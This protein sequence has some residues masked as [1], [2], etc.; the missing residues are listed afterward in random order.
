M[1]VTGV[2]MKEETF[3]IS[4]EFLLS[5][6]KQRYIRIIKKEGAYVCDLLEE[7][8]DPL[9]KQKR[10]RTSMDQRAILVS[11]ELRGVPVRIDA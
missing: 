6:R 11:V 3:A 8:K 5:C 2:P 9:A 1:A 4:N 10:G 7:A